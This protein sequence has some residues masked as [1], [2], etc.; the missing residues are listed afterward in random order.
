M[1]SRYTLLTVHILGMAINKGDCSSFNF[2]ITFFTP[3]VEFAEL[4]F[5]F[6]VHNILQADNDRYRKALSEQ[7]RSFFS[8][9][10]SATVVQSRANTPLSAAGMG[11]L[12]GAGKCQTNLGTSD[13]F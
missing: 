4:V 2:T 6:L 9:C 7:I 8:N 5:P 3:Q 10:N 12:S 13:T 11:P 1:Q